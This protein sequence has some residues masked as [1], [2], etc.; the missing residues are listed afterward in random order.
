MQRGL[1]RQCRKVEIE[2]NN[3]MEG[4]YIKMRDLYIRAGDEILTEHH[5]NLMTKSKSNENPIV[6]YATTMK[7]FGNNTRF[8]E[9]DNH[10]YPIPEELAAGSPLEIST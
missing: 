3:H 2:E 5:K 1:L 6:R 8:D 7:L 4:F 9:E 10:D